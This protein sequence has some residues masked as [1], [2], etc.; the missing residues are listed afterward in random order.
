MA[1]TSPPPQQHLPRRPLLSAE[2]GRLRTA[3]LIAGA[4]IGIGSG[5]LGAGIM[6]WLFVSASVAMLGA[7]MRLVFV[8]SLVAPTPAEWLLEPWLLWPL[9]AG[10]LLGPAGW[11]VSLLL[12]RHG[13]WGRAW[14]VTAAAGVVAALAGIVAS[15]ITL[16][17]GGALIW[18]DDGDVLAQAGTLLL[19]AGGAGAIAGALAGSGGWRW[20]G[21]LIQPP[22]RPAL[23][24][25]A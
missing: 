15:L 8:P 1:A 3:G 25:D 13:G 14:G 19:V 6:V 17:G 21:W 18:L 24:A 23:A 4:L 7:L 10:L 12:L 20:M 5:W 22:R 16:V 2:R 9:V 11:L